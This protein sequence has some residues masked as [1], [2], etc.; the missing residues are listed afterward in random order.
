MARLTKDFSADDTAEAKKQF[1]MYLDR[2]AWL[3]E[4][5]YDVKKNYI[6]KGTQV[7]DIQIR[8]DEPVRLLLVKSAIIYIPP[9]RNG[10]RRENPTD[11][12]IHEVVEKFYQK[13]EE[14][15]WE[16]LICDFSFSVEGLGVFRVNYSTSTNGAVLTI[17]I[18]SYQIP[19]FEFVGYPYIYRKYIGSLLKKTGTVYPSAERD[20]N[21]DTVGFVQGE[22]MVVDE[23]G[24][25]LHVGPTGSGKTTG[26]AAE[27]GFI[28]E[29]ASIKMVS[30]EN[31]LEYRYKLTKATVEQYE[32]GTNI[33]KDVT[34]GRSEMEVAQRLFLRATAPVAM[35]GEARNN[36]EIKILIDI[37][38]RGHLV[39][40]TIHAT[41][42]IEA[43]GNLIDAVGSGRQLLSQS[44]KAIVAHKLVQNSKGEIFGLHEILVI[45]PAIKSFIASGD[46][47]SIARLF[48]NEPGQLVKQTFG[49]S[50]ELLQRNKKMTPSEIQDIAS[51]NPAFFAPLQQGGQS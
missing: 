42:V 19:N 48:Y 9:S 41:N 35:I 20:E 27:F 8:Q 13:N 16:N 14:V 15:A 4:L 7:T 17:R 39:F 33:I 50:L 49:E 36:D 28:A 22:A 2:A 47:K 10:K 25:I 37:A 6:N 12:M 18:L 26:I 5:L 11:G 46:V 31:P 51:N 44:L 3:G 43:I 21:G 1:F 45:N 40:S 29:A 23:S 34:A 30:F 24:L 32:L 38:S